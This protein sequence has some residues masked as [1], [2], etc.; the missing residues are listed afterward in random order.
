M[1][2][3]QVLHILKQEKNTLKTRFGVEELALFG[4]YARG[5]ENPDSDVDLLVSF[6][7]IDF[8]KLMGAYIYIEKLLGKKV[9]FIRKGPHISDQFL[10]RIKK[11]MVYV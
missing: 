10:N 6:K 3:T 1:P 8:N 2:N 7:E 9:D 5:D 11:D 4:S